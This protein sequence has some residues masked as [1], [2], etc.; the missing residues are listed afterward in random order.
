MVR[1][2]AASGGLLRHETTI[3]HGLPPLPHRR[4]E[5]L[6]DKSVIV[7]VLVF[8]AISALS[9]IAQFTTSRHEQLEQSER[10]LAIAARMLA[11]EIAARTLREGTTLPSEL[12]ANLHALMEPGRRFLLVDRTGH[13]RAASDP[14]AIPG[15]SAGRL[16]ADPLAIARLD[17]RGTVEQFRL[18][19]GALASVVL[20]ED[21]AIGGAILA[22]QPVEDELAPWRR[23]VATLSAIL[24]AFGAVTIA[25][26]LAFHA[27]RQ[28]AA[29]AGN[30]A[31][32]LRS[33]FEVALEYGRCGLWDW[34]IAGDQVL[35]STSMR[36]LLGIGGVG[37]T[38]RAMI[39]ARLHPEDRDLFSRL[40]RGAETG[41][42]DCL[43]RMRH[44][45]GS[46]IWLRMR[47]I[48][49]EDAAARPGRLLGI[50]MDVTREREAEAEIH[51]ADARLRDAI[52]SISEAFVLW[53]DNNRLVLCN[54]KYQS[55]HGLSSECVRRGAPYKA[56]MAA[57]RAPQMLIEIDRGTEPT[58]GARC[59]EAQF[60]DGS[61][62]LISER[63]TRDGGYVSVGT[64]I[65]ARK[66]QEQQ[67]V[68]NE[69]QLRMTV[70]DL[71][72]SREA[73]RRQAGQLA[74]LADRYLEQKAEA[75][76]AN[77][78]KAEFL[79]NMNHEIRTPLNHIIGFAEII[80]TE[81]FGPAG[82]PRYVEYARD[83]RESG[84]SLLG[85]IADILDMARIEAGRVR[86]ERAPTPIGA[87]LAAAAEHVRDAAEAKGVT[88]RLE[89]DTEEQAG[90]RLIHVDAGAVSQALAHL[91][92]NGIRLSPAGGRVSVRARMA[93]D[94]VNIFIADRGCHLSPGEIDRLIAPFGHIDSMLEDGCKG[95]ALG[96]PIARALIE[97]HGGTMRLK[98]TPEIGSL[99]LVR[100]PV[101]PNPVQLSLL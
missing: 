87:L 33:Q 21:A 36:S 17:R 89:P 62:L 37:A 10:A 5:A 90:Q 60:E 8:L 55:F 44:E 13:I 52:E 11:G 30:R 49:V 77:R 20:V 28:R 76:S 26:T 22:I 23:R 65:T 94:H 7:L 84:A 25:F 80:E 83:I 14:A 15:L 81:M 35:W 48:F 31:L 43:F 74:E 78:A 12:P 51:R 2:F 56:V 79:A 64:D 58:T 92:R 70:T 59:Y 75:I 34:P 24:L 18:A 45:S 96:M 63:H 38:D 97:L 3:A 1:A 46:W 6:L 88:L 29:H 82:S 67:F 61:W 53:D 9:V 98:S 86:L 47:A 95:S 32:A 27:Q 72:N 73:F 66:L 40:G 16:F 4:R 85:L 50:V 19:D 99:V 91:M 57:A 39:E 42:L 41:E 71:G 54:S 68:E 101:A 93:G 69:R 100:L